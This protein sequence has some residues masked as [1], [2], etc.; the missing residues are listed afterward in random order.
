M[1]KQWK[2]KRFRKFAEWIDSANSRNWSISQI[3]RSN[4]VREGVCEIN[5]FKSSHVEIQLFTCSHVQKSSKIL[6]Q[7][8]VGIHICRGLWKNPYK[9]YTYL[10]WIWR[11]SGKSKP[12]CGKLKTI[13]SNSSSFSLGCLL[14]VWA[15]IPFN[16]MHPRSL[17]SLTF[18]SAVGYLD[19][20]SSTFMDRV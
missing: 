19:S 10:I 5:I 20:R 14:M 13:L 6:K 3:C 12:A 4:L 17:N 1:E 8:H 7:S 9:I 11:A 18:A 15:S 2:I 16:T